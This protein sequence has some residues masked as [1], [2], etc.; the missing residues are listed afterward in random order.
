MVGYA[1]A[2]IEGDAL[3]G[4]GARRVYHDQDGNVRHAGAR[5]HA[6]GHI[7]HPLLEQGIDPAGSASRFSW[8]VRD[9]MRANQRRGNKRETEELPV[10]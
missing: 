1:E 10:S 7:H 6:L 2:T 8:I 3:N 9:Q 4:I 5:D